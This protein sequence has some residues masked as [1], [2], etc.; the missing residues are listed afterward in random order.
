MSN[1]FLFFKTKKKDLKKFLLPLS[2]GEQFY[3]DSEKVFIY[4]FFSIYIK[5]IMYSFS[6]PS[7]LRRFLLAAGVRGIWLLSSA[8]RLDSSFNFIS[9]LA[10]PSYKSKVPFV[11]INI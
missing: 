6:L 7:L 9:T 3:F 8:R 11:W 10:F 4:K 1:P 5:I 2:R